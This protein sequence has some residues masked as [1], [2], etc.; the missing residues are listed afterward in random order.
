MKIKETFIEF[1]I[2]T[3]AHGIPNIIRAKSWILKIMWLFFVTKSSAFCCFMIFKSIDNYLDFEVVT[4]IHLQSNLPI[5]FPTVSICNWSPIV[6]DEAK[7]YFEENYYNL[8]EKFD[9]NVWFYKYSNIYNKSTDDKKNLGL[10]LEEFIYECRFNSK[11]CEY[12]KDFVWFYDFYNGNCFRF[13]SGR[14]S[15]GHSIGKKNVYKIGRYSNLELNIFT[16]NYSPEAFTGLN[17][18]VHNSSVNPSLTEG[19]QIPTGFQTYVAIKKIFINKKEYPYSDCISDINSH[20]SELVQAILKTGYKYRQI[21]C[22]DLC[23]QSYIINNAGCYFPGLLN[24]NDSKPCLSPEEIERYFNK[25]SEFLSFNLK[26]YCGPKCPLECDYVQ[27]NTESSY[28]NMKYSGDLHEKNTN[29]SLSVFYDSTSY[30][31]IEEMAKTD[32]I[33]LIANIGGT[34]GLF[35]GI[36]VLSFVEIFQLIGN[37]I[38][39][40]VKKNSVK[41]FDFEN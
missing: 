26:N 16:G 4:K 18:I 40:S 36:S 37:I 25:S 14:N 30:T 27:Y 6:T 7:V 13:N 5:E 28:A 22:F 17:I 31:T 10:K 38:I 29:L 24:L 32:L 39:F 33:D 1:G 11:A 3:T 15:T 21:D 23:E 35:L 8:T 20:K 41:T 34:L 9:D 19:F 12:E 2:E